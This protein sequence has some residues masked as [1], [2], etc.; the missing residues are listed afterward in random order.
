[1][2]K[3]VSIILP[4]IRP[5]FLETFYASVETA[6]Q[7]HSFE[8]VIPT[9]F[10]VTDEIKRRSNVKIVKTHSTPTVAK[11]MAIQ[12]CNA[13]FLYNCTD[14]GFLL[15]HVIDDAIS[16]RRWTNSPARP[17]R[18]SAG[19][20][21]RTESPGLRIFASREDP[22]HRAWPVSWVAGAL[23]RAGTRRGST[24]VL[25]PTPAPRARLNGDSH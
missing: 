14:D 11:Q 10:D 16:M 24:A 4:S 25:E 23:A 1:M 21:S 6:C 5:Q 19:H 9:P 17:R 22:P 8:L 18:T 3:D 12:L 15:E 20:R 2:K 7:N 13:E